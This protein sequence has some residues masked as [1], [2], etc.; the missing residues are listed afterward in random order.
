MVKGGLRGESLQLNHLVN[1]YVRLCEIDRIRKFAVRINPPRLYF[2]AKASDLNLPL[3]RGLGVQSKL[4]S[5]VMEG[6]MVQFAA[7]ETDAE[8]PFRWIGYSEDL[9][10]YQVRMIPGFWKGQL[11]EGF[12]VHNFTY[13]AF[14]NPWLLSPLPQ[15]PLLQRNNWILKTGSGTN[16][17]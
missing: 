14:F 9:G 16:R 2:T 15:F 7:W 11:H 8:T 17:S 6:T 10:N 5:K 3:D 4:T 13:S 1:L 12:L